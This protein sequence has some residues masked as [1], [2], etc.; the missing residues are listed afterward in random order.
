[1]T[2]N[3]LA[4]SYSSIPQFDLAAQFAI[5]GDEIREAVD[6][7]LSS[8]QFILGREGATLEE[9]IARGP[10]LSSSPCGPVGLA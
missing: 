5:I 8:H 7:V 2:P 6:R 9:E 3:P 4:T 10:T 1:M